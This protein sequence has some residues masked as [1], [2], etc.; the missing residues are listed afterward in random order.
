MFEHLSDKQR[1]ILN[2]DE[3]C[4]VVKACPGSGKTYSV[5]ARIARL[6][7]NEQFS[8]AGIAALSFTNVACE[9]ISQK[10]KEDF[11]YPHRLAYPNFIGTLDS[12][13]NNYVFLPYG[14]LVMECAK[15]PQLVGE[16]HGAWTKAKGSKKYRNANGRRV[17]YEA[18]P[19]Y[20]FDC[21]SFNLAGEIIP[22]VAE[23]EFH[24]SF[25]NY[26]KLNGDRYKVIQEL[27]DAKW[28]NF[29]LGFANQSDANY[30]S[31]Q[32]LLK[33]P[34]IVQT[35][36]RKFKYMIVD[37]AQDTNEV[38]MRLIELLNENGAKNV[39][40]IG[41]R[42]QSI[43]EW[44][45][46]DPSLFDKK[47][48]EWPG[49]ELNENRRSSQLICNFSQPL[50]SFERFFAVDKK[51]A[52]WDFQPR[53]LGYDRLAAG[54]TTVSF[55]RVMQQFMACCEE[56]DIDVCREKV[57][58]IYRGRDSAQYLGITKALDLHDQLPW[59]NQHYFVRE[60]VRGKYLLETGDFKAGYRLLER[61]LLEG[62]GNAKFPG[63]HLSQQTMNNAIEQLGFR[64]HRAY[65][66][67]LIRLLPATTGLTLDVWVDQTNQ[68]LKVANK[69]LVLKV[70]KTRSNLLITDIFGMET[71]ASFNFPFTLGTIHSV[72]G[73]TFEAVLL[74][75]GKK[76]GNKSNYTTMLA[77]G[78]KEG[79]HEELRNIYV[80]ITRPRKVLILAVPNDDAG[81]WM[82][83]MTHR[84]VQ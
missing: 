50:S 56:N 26:F 23:R 59:E 8:G 48:Q 39:M 10:L 79:E 3:G 67:D 41:D 74:M 46:A 9:E 40:L 69:A 38:Q 71:Q 45:H 49:I 70:N 63:Y 53:V 52:S 73:K 12:F 6:L 34:L 22:I 80:G 30:L 57:A 78:C 43:F 5:A 35:L 32:V 81:V 19:D 36:A 29:K 25:K 62:L 68:A 84:P 27:I 11:N 64:E 20:Y 51:V 31:L 15:R 54:V 44:N 1:V 17:C 60:L 61:G 75:V 4:F 33:Y 13:F 76:A 83:F 37:E 42:D 65:L 66:F 24:F 58:V 2:V 77:N 47:F 7:T 18:D 14:H 28:A 16:P 55:D 72:K 21:T 82:K